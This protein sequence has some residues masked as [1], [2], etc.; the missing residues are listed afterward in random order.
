MESFFRRFCVTNPALIKI[1]KISIRKFYPKSGQHIWSE[2][3]LQYS[4]AY[5]VVDNSLKSTTKI[6]IYNFITET[7]SPDS[8]S[9]R[10]FNIAVPFN[11]HAH[12]QVRGVAQTNPDRRNRAKT[13]HI[14]KNFTKGYFSTLSLPIQTHFLHRS[15][16]LRN[17]TAKLSSAMILTTP[18]QAF[19]G[20]SWSME[21]SAS[22]IFI[23]RN[24]K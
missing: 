18:S 3:T 24:T 7:S 5:N 10:C 4:L 11:F 2:L 1:V 9:N 23:L 16:H 22:S 17:T 13:V 8:F 21:M 15:Y 14:G 19:Y 6:T 12:C 20:V